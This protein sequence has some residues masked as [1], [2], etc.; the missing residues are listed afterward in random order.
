MTEEV[1]PDKKYLRGLARQVFLLW[2]R[3]KGPSLCL[4]EM[5]DPDDN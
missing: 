1:F 4:H 3:A 5:M 2:L